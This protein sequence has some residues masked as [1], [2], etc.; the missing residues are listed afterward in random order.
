MG[1]MRWSSWVVVG[2]AASG[3]AFGSGC[4]S[5]ASPDAPSADGTMPGAPANAPPGATS[6]PPGAGGS[7]PPSVASGSC[8]IDVTTNAAAL[9]MAAAA[10]EHA[11]V[12]EASS[13][14]KTSWAEKDNEAVVLEVLRGTTR[15]GHI[16]L[17]QGQ[18]RFAY[19]MHLGAL[20]AGEALQVRVS[21]LSATK[22]DKRACI[23]KV[24]LTAVADMGNMAD[25]IAHAPVVKWPA[26]KSFDDLP[27]LLGWSRAGKSY[28]LTYTNENG[29][30]TELCGGGARGLRSEIARWS[31]GLDM[32]GVWAYGGAGRFERCTGTVPPTPG[33][34]RME[35]AHPVLYYGDGHNRVFE[36]RGGYGQECGSGS[37]AKPNGDLA[38]WNTANPGNDESKDD[39][40]T[41][42]LRPLP[43]DMDA[44]GVTKLGGRREGIVDTYAPWLYRLT[45][46][47]AKRE[48]KIDGMQ[49]FDM[50]RYLLV[51]VYAADVGG[52][53]DS[54]CGPVSLTP[55][56]THVTGGF[57]LRAV[58][59]NG[60]VYDG[61]QMTADYF[62]G[63]GP[64]VKRIAIPLAAGVNAADIT[65]VVFDAYDD[66][67]IYFL[68]IGDA[69]IAKPSG[70]NGATLEYAHKGL[71]PAAV[72]VDD[73]QSGC[74]AGTNTKDGIAYP[75]VGSAYTFPL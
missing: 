44:I 13:I 40:F 42:V 25:G 49:T 7:E 9:G 26:Q 16:V 67:G 45:D 14:S 2:L 60:A 66:D 10:G 8:T 19:G 52:S 39:P 18:D 3:L 56:L 4:S 34:P 1:D 11:L 62:G 73:G 50:S 32:E 59:K 37:D 74:V 33:V 46:S 75:C 12:I 72:Y 41:I 38:G 29:G 68:G 23:S 51:D 22:A 36:S 15:I 31:R 53:G 48:G 47:E 27:V 65:K 71:K 20:N 69:F 55:S 54:T 64:A 21:P 30:T 35:S 58:A 57:I 63:T 17:H 61:P 6:D 43:V 28:Q 5:A 24:T 70:T